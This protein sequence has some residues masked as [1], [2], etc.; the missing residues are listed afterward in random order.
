[1]EREEVITVVGLPIFLLVSMM[2]PALI[3][4][5]AAEEIDHITIGK[6][7]ALSEF[8]PAA[9]DEADAPSPAER[10]RLSRGRSPCAAATGW[11]PAR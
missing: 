6:R 9:T 7:P 3:R 10:P 5:F 11:R 1:M 2:I 4:G 8:D